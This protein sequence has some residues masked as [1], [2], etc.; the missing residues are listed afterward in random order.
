MEAR[1]EGLVCADPGARTPISVSGNL[2]G[3]Y[4]LSHFIIIVTMLIIFKLNLILAM[5]IIMLIE[6]EEEKITPLISATT[7]A[8]L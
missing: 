2:S 6:K 5:F 8:Q 4:Q 1:A 7:L 3:Q